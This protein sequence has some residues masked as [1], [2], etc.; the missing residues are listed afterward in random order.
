MLAVS[1]TEEAMRDF[2]S[3]G[4]FEFPVMLGGDEAARAYR[5]QA[6]KAYPEQPARATFW[7]PLLKC[8]VAEYPSIEANI[9]K[10]EPDR[11]SMSHL[12][13]SSARRPAEATT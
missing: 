1:D 5:V 2:M 8:T 10:M 9:P 4:S 7:A 13:S 12:A 11:I 6:E 3:A